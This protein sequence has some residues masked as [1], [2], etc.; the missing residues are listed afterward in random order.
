MDDLRVTDTIVIP[1]RELQWRFSTTGGPGG[2]HAN[3]AATRAELSFDLEASTAL[4]D[5]VRATIMAGLGRGEGDGVVIVTASASRSQWRNRQAA[6]RRLAELLREAMQVD[7][8]RRPTRPGRGAKR[9][10]LEDKRRRGETKR[11]RRR[12]EPE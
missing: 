6:R 8:P 3:R 2:Q 4:D 12:P 5:D 7:P 9:R 11:L 10:R 1:G